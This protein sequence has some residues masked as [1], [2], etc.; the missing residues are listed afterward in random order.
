MHACEFRWCEQMWFF[1][2][3]LFR[4]TV[5]KHILSRRRTHTNASS[6]SLILSFSPALCSVYC[7]TDMIHSIQKQKWMAS[8]AFIQ[9]LFTLNIKQLTWAKS[10]GLKL[11][12]I[13]M[14]WQLHVYTH[15]HTQTTNIII[16]WLIIYRSRTLT[17]FQSH[18]CFT[19][20]CLTEQCAFACT[21]LKWAQNSFYKML[22]NTR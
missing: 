13:T 7:Y 14:W 18:C 22:R 11:K 10:L 6:N 20:I 15:K 9:H 17:P 5:P 19:L 21:V 3:R 8:L 2:R 4:S 16:I 1:N 12:L